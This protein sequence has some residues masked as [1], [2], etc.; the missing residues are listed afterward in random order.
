MA[1]LTMRMRFDVPGIFARDLKILTE[2]ATEWYAAKLVT[3]DIKVPNYVLQIWLLRLIHF[4][5]LSPEACLPYRQHAYRRYS[6]EA[7]C[8]GS[9][10]RS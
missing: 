3:P 8:Y 10:A 1:L 5:E 7:S 6:T 4:I 2:F 9:C